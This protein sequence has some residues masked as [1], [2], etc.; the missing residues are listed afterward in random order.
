[1]R[2][3]YAVNWNETATLEILE[4]FRAYGKLSRRIEVINVYG[5]EEWY[6]TII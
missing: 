5:D 6:Y 3:I 4:L 2:N 1:M